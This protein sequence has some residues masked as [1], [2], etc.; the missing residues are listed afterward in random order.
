MTNSA[1]FVYKYL[2]LYNTQ[3]FLDSSSYTYAT[4]I[5]NIPLIIHTAQHTYLFRINK[6]VV[7]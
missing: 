3:I 7:F 4:Y 2:W 6:L 1:V 5:T